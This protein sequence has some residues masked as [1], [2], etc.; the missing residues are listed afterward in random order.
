MVS[1][2]PEVKRQQRADGLVAITFADTMI[3]STY[4]VAFVVGP[5]EATEW[6]DVDGIRAACT[7]QVKAS[8]RVR[9]DVAEFCLKWFQ[10]YYGIPYPGDKVELL[11]LPISPQERWRI[12]GAS[13]S[14]ES[15]SR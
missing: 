7:H 3:M 15:P 12:W 9:L 4:L 6:R 10:D 8:H 2:S 14:R 13:R 5:L 1:N 11:A